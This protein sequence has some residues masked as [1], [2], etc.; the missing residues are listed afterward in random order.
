MTAEIQI[1]KEHRAVVY[2]KPGQV[3]TAVVTVPT[4]TP[5][6]GEVLIRLTHSGVCSSDHG[7]MTQQWSHLPPT[8][9]NQIGGHE[10]VGEIIS[11]GPSTSSSGNLKIGSRVGIKW[12]ASVCDSG[13]CIACLSGR[14]A[15]CPG[16]K[17]SGFYYP[18]TFQQY[19]V[20]PAS[21]VT[22]IPDGVAS[23]MAAP[24]LCGGVTVYAALKKT[25][26][27]PGDAVVIS[28]AGGGLGHL[29]VQIA[30][31]GMG[32]R[33]IALDTGN[34]ESFTKSLG[35]ESFFDITKYP[36]SDPESATKLAT[37]V[38]KATPRGMGAASVVVCTGADA[39]YAQALDFLAFGGSLVCVGI[40]EGAGP[41]PIAGALPGAMIA[42]EL[43]ILGS[44]V[45]NRKDAIETMDMAARG[46]I[47]THFTVE[48]MSRLT[49]VFEKMERMELQGRVV[50]DL[51][52]E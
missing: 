2:D 8:P 6:V 52:R 15:Q 35:A 12:L 29:A 41:V 16:Q 4:P 26:A 21:Y 24:L 39:A 44:A 5:G 27:Q 31:R 20:A 1:P 48:P 9:Q 43:R 11:F 34:K 33:V 3:S 38:K 40:P 19:A 32:F 7:I 50:L 36:R 46:V 37:D 28:G 30:S 13:S 18:G 22:P 49:E 25:G 42:R 47:K 45:G 10:G 23:E 14:D 51:S 17:I